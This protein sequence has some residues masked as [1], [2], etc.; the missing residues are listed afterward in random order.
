MLSQG[1][2][3][4]KT[5]NSILLDA[6]KEKPKGNKPFANKWFPRLC[7]LRSESVARCQRPVFLRKTPA[8]E[9]RRLGGA[10]C[11]VLSLLYQLVKRGLDFVDPKTF[12]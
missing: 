6:S 11:L 2:L 3:A 12:R 1:K 4:F 7:I 10:Q 5:N 8:L 9:D